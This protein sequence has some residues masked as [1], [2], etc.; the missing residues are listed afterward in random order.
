MTLSDAVAESRCDWLLLWQAAT[1]LST[2]K[3]PANGF[4]WA[5]QNDNPLT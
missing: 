2:L 4:A 1:P 3:A 5:R